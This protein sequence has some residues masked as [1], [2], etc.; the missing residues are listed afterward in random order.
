MIRTTIKEKIEASGMTQGEFS[1]AI[2]VALSNFNAF[3]N[4][5]RSL[6]YGKLI[7]T[8]EKLNLSIG[9]K[10]AKMAPLPPTELPMIFKS[11][12]SVSGMKIREIADRAGVDNTCLTSFFNG[13]RNMPVKN[14]EKV[15]AVLNLDLVPYISKKS[16]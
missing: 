14:L 8:F 13:Y 1:K 11:H 10:G 2:G 4:G 16:A 7:M 6:P 3:L 15:M 5:S 9:R 12:A